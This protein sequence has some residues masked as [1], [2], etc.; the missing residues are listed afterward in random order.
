MKTSKVVAISA[1]TTVA[2]AFLARKLGVNVPGFR[3]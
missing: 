2:G 1:I 3:G